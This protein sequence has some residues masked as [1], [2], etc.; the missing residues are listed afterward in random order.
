MPKITRSPGSRT[1]RDPEYAH[2]WSLGPVDGAVEDRRFLTEVLMIPEGLRGPVSCEG[3]GVPERSWEGFHGHV[4]VQG[5]CLGF[6]RTQI[7]SL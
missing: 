6:Y 5:M 1:F 4:Y 2:V 3:L 7:A